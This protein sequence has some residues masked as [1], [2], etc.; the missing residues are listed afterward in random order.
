MK[1]NKEKSILRVYNKLAK[2]MDKEQTNAQRKLSLRDRGRIHQHHIFHLWLLLSF[3][4]PRLL[5]IITI[6]SSEPYCMHSNWTEKP[7][8]PRF[9]ELFF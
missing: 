7:G 8:S 4:S 2:T 9:S 1:S 6:H 5:V 3:V